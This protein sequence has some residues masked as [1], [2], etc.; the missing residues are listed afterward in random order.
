[1]CI[2]YEK[3]RGKCIEDQMP[4]SLEQMVF[5]VF[6]ERSEP[7][8]TSVFPGSARPGTQSTFSLPII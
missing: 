1:M 2:I 7:G 4:S 6:D 8:E 3:G 5:Y